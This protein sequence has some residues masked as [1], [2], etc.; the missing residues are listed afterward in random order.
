MNP[1]DVAIVD[2]G[3]GNNA[4]PYKNEANSGMDAAEQKEHDAFVRGLPSQEEMRAKRAKSDKA[5][6]K[7]SELLIKGWKM[8]GECCNE[9]SVPLMENKKKEIICTGCDRRFNANGE[10]IVEK[11]PE[12]APAPTQEK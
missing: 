4:I 7:M 9:C 8:L 11:K 6:S 12:V 10:P 1:E 5:A 2:I 3:S